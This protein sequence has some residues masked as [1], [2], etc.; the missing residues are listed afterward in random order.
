MHDAEE[1]AV[2]CEE[3]VHELYLE[4]AGSVPV[5]TV[6]IAGNNACSNRGSCSICPQNF[7]VQ[8]SQESYAARPD[9][10]KRRRE[11]YPSCFVFLHVAILTLYLRPAFPGRGCNSPVVW[12]SIANAN[13]CQCRWNNSADQRKLQLSTTDVNDDEDLF[14]HR[15]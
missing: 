5:V 3:A 9:Y 8:N 6:E 2:Y 15:S 13:E 7:Q 4:D 12:R 10:R 14:A 11:L 1:G